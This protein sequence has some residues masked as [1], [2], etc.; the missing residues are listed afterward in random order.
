MAGIYYPRA[1]V[2]SRRGQDLVSL[3]FIGLNRKAKEAL[4]RVGINDNCFF[5][6]DFF[7]Y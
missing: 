1:Y 5:I 3:R 7:R 2:F 6:D 4:Y